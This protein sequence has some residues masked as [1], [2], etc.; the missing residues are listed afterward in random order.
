MG[1]LK[2]AAKIASL[3]SPSPTLPL[4]RL[5]GQRL[6]LPPPTS[7]YGCRSR[8][9]LFLHS[10]WQGNEGFVK[11]AFD[12]RPETS[13]KK[14]IEK[15]LSDLVQKSIQKVYEKN[16][17]EVGLRVLKYIWNFWEF[18]ISMG[19]RFFDISNVLRTFGKY[20]KKYISSNERKFLKYC[21]I[22]F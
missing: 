5:L 22:Y 17:L 1:E 2:E 14:R 9:L 18:N 19:F 3:R 20:S 13:V 16:I 12:S 4:S 21:L 6:P 10:R 15:N 7:R 11:F 8:L